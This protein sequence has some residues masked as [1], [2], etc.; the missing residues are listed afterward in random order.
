MLDLLGEAE[1]LAETLDDERRLARVLAY[2]SRC[3]WWLGLP[4]RGVPAGERALGIGTSLGDVALEAG[5]NYH[6]GLNYVA[7]GDFGK[8]IEIYRRSEATLAAIEKERFGM[9]GLPLVIARAWRGYSLA[10]LGRFD[11]GLS[12]VE[13]G[14]R[15]AESANHP[16][17]IAAAVVGVGP[18]HVLQGNLT[19]AIQW[20]ERS[21]DLARSGDFAILTAL[22]LS[23]LGRA[24]TLVERSDA[25][26]ILEDAVEYSASIQFMAFHAADLAWLAYVYL[27]DGQLAEGMTTIERAL[28]LATTHGQRALESEVCLVLGTMKTLSNSPHFDQAGSHFLRAL[29]VAEEIGARPLVAHCHLGLGKLYRRTGTREQAQEHL[30]TATT[31]YREMDMRFWLEGAEAEMGELR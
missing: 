10:S 17:S 29:S 7:A 31:M 12:T 22:S 6:V 23:F 28:Q 4:S 5:A 27:K 11:E 18:V 30:T 9:P 15:L 26:Q 20:L 1:R 3:F 16:Y 2:R 25:R 8:A 19:S 13:S 24:L 21:L 14:V